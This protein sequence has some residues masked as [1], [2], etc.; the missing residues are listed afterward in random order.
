MPDRR[1]C[2]VCIHASSFI[3]FPCSGTSPRTKTDE[4]TII[5]RTRNNCQRPLSTNCCVTKL[6]NTDEKDPGSQT[7]VL[8]P[9]FNED[10]EENL[11]LS[12]INDGIFTEAQLQSSG[13]ND[14]EYFGLLEDHGETFSNNPTETFTFSSFEPLIASTGNDDI[15]SYSTNG[16]DLNEEAGFFFPSRQ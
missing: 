8:L 7:Q 3:P 6:Q 4:E 5:Q 12:S 11:F 14:E 13:I 16:Q 2:C 1:I 9:T 15:L 10:K